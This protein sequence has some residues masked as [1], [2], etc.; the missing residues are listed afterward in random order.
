MG[1]K[2]EIMNGTLALVQ[3]IENRWTEAKTELA[4]RDSA[5]VHAFEAYRTLFDNQML[6]LPANLPTPTRR[7][8]KQWHTLL[9]TT[10]EIVEETSKLGLTIALLE[11]APNL[12]VARFYYETW[13]QTTHNLCLRVKNLVTQ[14]CRIHKRTGAQNE[15]HAMIDREV[16]SQIKTRRHPLVHGSGNTPT[17]VKQAISDHLRG[18]EFAVLL[19]PQITEHALEN[20]YAS[21]GLSPE[22]YYAMLN[23]TTEIILLKLGEILALLERDLGQSEAIGDVVP[24][25]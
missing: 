25:T 21:G 18:W 2:R 8:P 10:F 24:V 1:A 12:R 5:F 23:K 20:A 19:G 3:F 6:I 14:S 17:I 9:E 4:R 7:L 11:S 15:Y 16:H 22:Q 13:L